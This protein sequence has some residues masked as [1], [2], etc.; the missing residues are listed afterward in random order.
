MKIRGILESLKTGQPVTGQIGSEILHTKY[1]NKIS[2]PMREIHRAIGLNPSRK[3][4]V[5]WI[6]GLPGNGKTQL[7]TQCMNAIPQLGCAGKYSCLF[8]KFDEMGSARDR[9]ILIQ[10][11]IMNSFINNNLEE[12]NKVCSK[13][14]KDG[15]NKNIENDIAFGVDVISG[16]AQIPSASLFAVSG[17]K[18]IRN[19]FVRREK[20]IIGKLRRW[21]KDPNILELLHAWIKYILKPTSLHGEDLQKTL[22]RLSSQVDLFKLFCYLLQKANYSTIILIFD[23]M[24]IVALKTL[25]TLWDP[26]IDE[27]KKYYHNMNIIMLLSSQNEVWENAMQDKQLR[28]RFCKNNSIELTGPH[29]SIDDRQDFDHIVNYVDSLLNC[30]PQLRLK[31]VM[32]ANV[33]LEDYYNDLADSNPSWQ[34]IWEGV[35]D[36]LADI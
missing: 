13:I 30:A 27:S 4:K 34:D 28:R 17:I 33:D 10:T 15:I 9:K 12:V 6:Q 5:Y 36:I 25:K 24:D 7:L 21:F 16:L 29:I 23:E 26:P 1:R 8:L 22:D 32:D 18:R 14:L 2:A 35:I 20:Y 3:R 19:W 11:I 31:T